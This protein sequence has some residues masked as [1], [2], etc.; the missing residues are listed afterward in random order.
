MSILISLRCWN[1]G[2]T[3]WVALIV[4]LSAHSLVTTHRHYGEII[5]FHCLAMNRMSEKGRQYK[6]ASRVTDW[7]NEWMTARR[8]SRIVRLPAKIIAAIPSSLNSHIVHFFSIHSDEMLQNRIPSSASFDSLSLIDCSFSLH[9]ELSMEMFRSVYLSACRFI[10]ITIQSWH[11]R[12]G[13]WFAHPGQCSQQRSSHRSGQFSVWD[14]YVQTLVIKLIFRWACSKGI[15]AD[16][17]DDANLTTT[18]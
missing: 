5:I 1:L 11:I 17:E 7:M 18:S 9:D 6:S 3:I 16:N 15:I 10:P 14:F 8:Q 2:I 13:N 4:C 12:H